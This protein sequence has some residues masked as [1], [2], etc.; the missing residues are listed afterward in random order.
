MNSVKWINGTDNDLISG[1]TDHT[2]IVWK[3]VEC[4]QWNPF[5]LKGHDSNVNLVDGIYKNGKT[6]IVTVSMDCSV[7]IWGREGTETFNLLQTINLGLSIS[8]G[9]AISELPG[10]D[11]VIIACALDN[12]TIDLYNNV[13]QQEFQKCGTLKGHEDWVRGLDFTI[14]GMWV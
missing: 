2:A 3:W 12:S 8:V 11:S 10:S 9:I 7:K 13:Q 4:G 5:L 1:S 6:T 14:D